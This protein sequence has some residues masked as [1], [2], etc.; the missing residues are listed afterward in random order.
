MSDNFITK[1]TN[2][3]NARAVAVTLLNECQ[4]R[5]NKSGNPGNDSDNNADPFQNPVSYLA[6]VLAEKAAFVEFRP[7]FVGY[8]KAAL[9]LLKIAFGNYYRPLNHIELSPTS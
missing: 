3:Y 2:D 8:C 4:Y 6:P 1:A 5:A 7:S 9:I